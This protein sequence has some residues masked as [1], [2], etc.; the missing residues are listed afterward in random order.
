MALMRT[1]DFAELVDTPLRKV[2]YEYLAEVPMEHEEWINKGTTSRNFEDDHI[3]SGLGAVPSKAEGA[4]VQFEDAVAGTTRR[5]T[6]AA[7]ALG[8]IITREMWDDDLHGVMKRMTEALQRS[9][10]NLYEVEAYKI[11]NNATATTP[12]RYL[13]LD[14]LALLNTAHT[15][16]GAGGTQGNTPSSQVDI[17][18]TAV[19]SAMLAFHAFKD[20]QNLPIYLDPQMAVVSGQDMFNAGEIF[21]NAGAEPNTADRNVN[22]VTA[23]PTGNGISKVVYSRFFT[24]TDMWFLLSDKSQHTLTMLVRTPCEFETN[25]DFGTGN[26][27]V[28]AFTR[29]ITGFS[30]W[31]GV[32]GSTGA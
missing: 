29:L 16:L 3:V 19:Q 30:H 10:R 6:P 4:T 31:Y 5:Y 20:D 28:K 2:Y 9:C 25:D 15:Q 14:G 17:S 22:L 26:V 13:G 7:F 21:R 23:G 32:Y 18:Y 1:S 24:D 8:F 12:N 27:Q 11:F